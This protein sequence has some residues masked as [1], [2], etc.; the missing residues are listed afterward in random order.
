LTARQLPPEAEMGEMRKEAHALK[1]AKSLTDRG[2]RMVDLDRMEKV[3]GGYIMHVDSRELFRHEPGE[4][5]S[6]RPPSHCFGITS[7][8]QLR[9]YSPAEIT[10]EELLE[11]DKRG[12][13]SSAE[14]HE[15]KR[16]A[17]AA[18]ARAVTANDYDHALPPTL[19]AVA[20]RLHRHGGAIRIEDGRVVVSLP[21]GEIGQGTLGVK[22]AA[23]LY[24]AHEAIIEA[25]RGKAG[26]VAFYKL[27]DRPC[28]PSGKLAP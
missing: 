14:E 25:M 21:P 26:V 23:Y 15:R 13:K 1:Q 20:E 3:K 5:P 18:T 22:L 8:W 17:R 2:Y 4:P 10:L 11:R 19:R 6:G 9:W 27:P 16:K 7:A 24:A 12:S 28:L